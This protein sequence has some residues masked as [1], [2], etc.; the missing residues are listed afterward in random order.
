MMRNGS[1]S[2]I[3]SSLRAGRRITADSVELHDGWRRALRTAPSDAEIRRRLSAMR[4]VLLGEPHYPASLAADPTAPAAVFFRGD[5]SVIDRHRRVAVIGTR[6]ATEHGR[7]SAHDLGRVLAA[8]D[9]SVVSGLALGIDAAAHRGVLS[10]NG[11]PPIGVVA[12]GLDVVYPRTNARLWS[13]VAETGVLISESPPGTEPDRFRFPLRNRIIAALA[14][15]VVVVESRE[16]GGSMLTVNEA[17]S[18]DVPVMAVPGATRSLASG[19]TNAL[20]RDGALV[21]ASPDDVLAILGLTTVRYGRAVGDVGELRP[22]PIGIDREVL[23]VMT[24]DP[25]SLDDIARACPSRTLGD[26]ALGLGRLEANG[27]V[28]CTD[29]WFELAHPSSPCSVP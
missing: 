17:L 13:D 15:V 22:V 9:V 7:G 6:R 20:L 5:L 27:W 21:A 14:D 12:S 19:G 11:A 23:S 28:V 10:V 29:G 4:V 3:E 8:N 24:S 18:R 25:R 1:P 2:S 26:V 16:T